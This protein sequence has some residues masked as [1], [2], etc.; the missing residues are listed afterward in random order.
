MRR[1]SGWDDPDGALCCYSALREGEACVGTR[2]QEAQEG[3]KML[4]MYIGCLLLV[5]LRASPRVE[6]QR[7]GKNKS[8]R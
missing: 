5:L 2:P 4:V 1:R 7:T 6:L 8:R 3:D